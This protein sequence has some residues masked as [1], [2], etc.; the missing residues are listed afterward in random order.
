M[1]VVA[2][3]ISDRFGGAR[4]TQVSGIGLIVFTVLTSFYVAARL[5]RR[6]HAVRPGMVGMFFFAGIG[7]ASTFK[8]IPCCSRSCK[9]AGVIGWTA[10]IAAYG[11]F[12]FSV[13]I[14]LLDL[15]ERGSPRAFFY[16]LTAFYVANLFLNWW[17]FARRG[18]PDPC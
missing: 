9:A 1:R 17:F 7:N 15:A 10:A 3:P 8:Q 2:G 6:L 16:G 5:A 12:L 13:L 14:S 4:V 18:A 11:P